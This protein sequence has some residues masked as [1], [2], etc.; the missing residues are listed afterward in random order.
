M[1]NQH[2]IRVTAN[3]RDTQLIVTDYEIGF[4]NAY[5]MPIKLLPQRMT[6]SYR[7]LQE[8]KTLRPPTCIS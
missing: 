5:P 4:M 2:V 8:G 1:I 3:A 7:Y 6:F